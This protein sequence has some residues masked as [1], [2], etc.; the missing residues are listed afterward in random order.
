MK[1]LEENARNNIRRRLEHAKKEGMTQEILA[2]KAKMSHFHFNK[3]LTGKKRLTRKFVEA[4]APHLDTSA[5]DLYMYSS[6]IEEMRIQYQK[7]IDL[8]NRIIGEKTLEIEL[9]KS[10]SDGD[11]PAQILLLGAFDR[12]GPLWRSMTLAVATGDKR[13]LAAAQAEAMKIAELEPSK[14]P[15][16]ARLAG[17]LD[18][19]LDHKRKLIPS[20]D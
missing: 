15:I 4:V 9:L 7:T 17:T 16:A 11:D 5:D 8:Q 18:D 19:L 10:H 3:V 13:L 12:S 20:E 6:E 14:A 2:K 1:K